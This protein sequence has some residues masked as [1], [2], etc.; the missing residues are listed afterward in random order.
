MEGTRPQAPRE[1]SAL[2]E[3]S[4]DSSSRKRFLKLVGGTG[5]AS[6]LAL[7]AAACGDDE[8]ETTT[9]AGQDTGQTQ[10]DTGDVEIVN[11]ALTLEHL[12]NDFYRQVV[13][14][15]QIKDPKIAD[16]AKKIGENE[17]EHVDALTA[18]VEQ[19]GGKAVTAPQTKFDEVLA[20][21]P[22]KILETA[23]MVENLGAAAYLGQAD[24]IKSPDILAAALSIHT[25][26]ARHAAAV[27]ELAGNKFKGGKLVGSL[28]DGSFAKP[29][30]EDEVMKA[31]QPFLA[32]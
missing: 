27:N 28:P 14:S 3:I 21:G 32:A 7:L 12:E 20:G 23:A 9:G 31:V 17:Q 11:Y 30:S 4:R 10:V 19:L 16:T 29:M 2:E 15:G 24:K 6:A 13:D 22:K 8:E 26:E 18:T 25:V 1:G 5:A